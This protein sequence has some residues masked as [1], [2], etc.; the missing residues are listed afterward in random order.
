MEAVKCLKPC[1]GRNDILKE[2]YIREV[3]GVVM[4]N[5]LGQSLRLSLVKFYEKFGTYLRSL[6]MLGLSI[7]NF[8]QYYIF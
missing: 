2:F 5:S 4:N 1:F 8:R 7:E 3:L 6:K